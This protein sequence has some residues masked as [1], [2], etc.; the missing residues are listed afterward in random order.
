MCHDREE[1]LDFLGMYNSYI[2]YAEIFYGYNE[3]EAIYMKCALEEIVRRFNKNPDTPPLRIIED[4][5]REMDF[6][7][8]FNPDTRHMFSTA[9]NVAEGILDNIM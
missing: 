2:D 5:R 7:S 6:Y 3:G 8:H 1:V 9:R 4:F